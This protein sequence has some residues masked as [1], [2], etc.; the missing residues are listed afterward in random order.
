MSKLI[1]LAFLCCLPSAFVSAQESG[2]DDSVT[3]MTAMGAVGAGP[4]C[5]P[6]VWFVEPDSPAASG[7]IQ[8]GDRLLAVDGHRGIDAAQARP[9]L[10]T[11]DS[12]PVT[13]EIEGE[14][15]TYTV[16]VGR[17]KESILLKREGWKVGPDGNRYAQDATDA[18]MKRVAGIKEPPSGDRVFDHHYPKNVELY[19]PGFEAL[20][21]QDRHEIVVWAM[22]DGGPAR[23]AGMHYG[24][25]IVSVDGVDPLGKSV[26]EV[27]TLLSSSGPRAMTL[28]INRDGVTKTF[29]F[30][31]IKAA[32]LMRQ[33]KKRFYEG[34]IIPSVIPDAYLHCF[35]SKH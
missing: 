23:K 7:G 28:V 29:T 3:G 18:E 5:P 17:V 10:H 21:L 13:L 9:L 33:N 24:D 34:K 25:V 31:L 20:V 2:T 14:H 8:P 15:G 12:K 19:Y 32:D 26:A 30:D 27:E 16:T 4:S 22:E 11:K 35:E 1:F 6:I